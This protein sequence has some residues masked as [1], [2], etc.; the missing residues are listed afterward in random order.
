MIGLIGPRFSFPPIRQPMVLQ[1]HTMPKPNASDSRDGR[2]EVYTWD[3]YDF[4]V[5]DQS[6]GRRGF[7]DGRP[8]KDG[9][10]PKRAR[11]VEELV[12]REKVRRAQEETKK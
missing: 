1:K 6:F 7:Y 4:T 10:D 3:L 12:R 9:E 5:T 11:W 8:R 2:Q